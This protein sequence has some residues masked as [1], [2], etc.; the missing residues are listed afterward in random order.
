MTTRERNNNNKKKQDTTMPP[1]K[2]ISR[3]SKLKP[4]LTTSPTEDE[5]PQTISVEDNRKSHSKFETD[6]GNGE[7]IVIIKPLNLQTHLLR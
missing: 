3:G 7:R 5:P 1:E 6:K 2:R 4:R